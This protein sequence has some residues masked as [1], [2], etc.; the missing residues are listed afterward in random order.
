MKDVTL[1]CCI[2]SQILAYNDNIMTNTQLHILAIVT[3]K[4]M[5]FA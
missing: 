2:I 4:Y 3:C 5:L 1:I